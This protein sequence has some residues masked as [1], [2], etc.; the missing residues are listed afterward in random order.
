VS[1][2]RPVEIYL[3]A[4]EGSPA[5]VGAGHVM[6]ALGE[7]LKSA[8]GMGEKIEEMMAAGDAL[9]QLAEQADDPTKVVGVARDSAGEVAQVSRIGK[10]RIIDTIT[11]QVG[12]LEEKAI[13]EA[14]GYRVDHGVG[15]DRFL[16]E[17]LEE[18][19]VQRSTDAV[20]DPVLRWRFDEGERVETKDGVHFDHYHFF[21]K[22]SAATDRRLVTELASEK[23]DDHSDSAEEYARKSL[24]PTDRP[25]SRKND[26]WT[27]SISGLVEER[28]RTETVLGPR[29]EAWENIRARIGAAT[30]YRSLE[31]A[32]AQGLIHVDEDHDEIWIP[33]SMVADAV[34]SVETSRRALQSELAERGIDSDELSGS[35]ISEAVKRGGSVG[36]FWRLDATHEDVPEPENIQDEVTDG[37]ERSADVEGGDNQD[38]SG[39]SNGPETFGRPPEDEDDEDGD[40]GEDE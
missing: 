23:A 38:D 27:R 2:E 1:D 40:G 5:A 35:G 18:V 12:D 28:S 20:D 36:R 15:L 19:V 34:E 39:S 7:R 4:A 24:G 22:L 16:E 25:W 13:E 33:T 9:A 14:G 21:K 17:H 37:T 26:L 6:A 3:T 8:D 10:E 11:D 31:D 29:T 32:V 30:G